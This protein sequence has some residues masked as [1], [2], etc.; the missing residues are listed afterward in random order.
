MGRI[1]GIG[2]M[3]RIEWTNNKKLI[4][5]LHFEKAINKIIFIQITKSAINVIVRLAGCCTVYYKE[6]KLE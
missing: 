2:G 4:I 1:K 5:Y 3:G 6:N